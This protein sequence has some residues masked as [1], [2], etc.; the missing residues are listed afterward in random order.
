MTLMYK[1]R[2]VSDPESYLKGTPKYHSYDKNGRLFKTLGELRT[3]LSGVITRYHT[4]NIADWEIV[5]IELI[6]KE[7]KSVND[8][9]T[10]KTLIK[11]LVK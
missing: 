10:A 1:I 3:F 8:V 7:I 5:E 2:L 6:H 4:L 9:I 11:L